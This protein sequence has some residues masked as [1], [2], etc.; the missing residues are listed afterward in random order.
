MTENK[1]YR[2][3]IPATT[4][5]IGSGF[6]VLGIS[7]GLYN[8]VEFKAVPGVDLYDTD[9]RVEGEGQDQIEKGRR[10]MILRA[11][12]VTADK[13]GRSICGGHMKLINRIPLAR[14][15]GSSSA[16]L[17]SGVFLSNYLMDFPFNTMDLLNI[18]SNMEGHPDNAA[19]AIL[20]GFCVS[21]LNN[22]QVT[23]ERIDIPL[24]WKAVV[25]IPNFELF[26]EK[27]RAVLPAE[28]KRNDVVHNIS[29]VSFLMLAFMSQKPEYLGLGLD[30]KIHVPYRLHL[31]P[32]AKEAIHNALA[33]GAYGATISGS[34]PTI[35]A[36]TSAE[37]SDEVGKAMV[38]G[39][40]EM[41]IDSRYLVLDFDH[42]GIS[43]IQY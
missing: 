18:T 11:M 8:T 3:R 22:G 43:V 2:I 23:A 36:F 20:G 31:I 7:L 37:K 12:E 16:A 28:Y 38:Q 5:N 15:L 34:G 39:F 9:I 24:S 4:A 19:P 30:D 40:K 17:A 35:I 21:A 6:D 41:S 10:N 42:D 32:G 26:T 29:A 14:G 1:I 33:Q 25:V 13:A 27:A